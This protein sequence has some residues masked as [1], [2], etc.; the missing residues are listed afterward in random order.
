MS[1]HK[2][3]ENILQT[4][5]QESGVEVVSDHSQACFN[6]LHHLDVEFKAQAIVLKPTNSSCSSSLFWTILTSL[7]ATYHYYRDYCKIDQQDCF[8]T[9]TEFMNRIL[10][11]FVMILGKDV[12]D[13]TVNGD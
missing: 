8:I 1:A 3:D 11:L 4:F 13:T 10:D 12:C 6:T 9:P 2:V 5:C 7:K